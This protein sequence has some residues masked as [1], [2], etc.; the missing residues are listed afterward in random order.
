MKIIASN[1]RVEKLSS[2]KRALLALRALESL[3]STAANRQGTIARCPRADGIL[4][5]P[6]SFAQERLWFLDQMEPGGVAYNMTEAI[7]IEGPLQVAAVERTVRDMVRRHEVLRT[8]F[9]ARNGAPV[10]VVDG[11]RGLPLETIDWE[12]WDGA[13]QERRS[14]ELVNAEAGTAFDLAQGPLLRMKLARLG[15]RRHVLFLAMHHVISDGWSMGVLVRE[16]MELYAAFS[17]GRPSPLAELPIQ[18]VDYAVW[19]REWL[20]GE[21][22]AKQLGYWRKKLAGAPVLDLPTDRPRSMMPSSQGAS[23]RVVISREPAPGGDPVHGALGGIQ[24]IAEPI[25]RSGG[26]R[27]GFTDSQSEPRGDGGVDWIL[28]EHLGVTDGP[29]RGSDVLGVAGA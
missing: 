8:R 27:G 1:S 16:F 10:Q 4:A 23:E 29:G 20:Q 24:D 12:G 9:E 13:E 2:A 14:Q 7:Q 25:Q 11:E 18:Y 21:V 19:Q 17:A 5:F 26:H 15:A 3:G 22:L 28:C 6:L